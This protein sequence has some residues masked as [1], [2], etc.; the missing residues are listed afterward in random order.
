MR[1]R[2]HS[3]RRTRFLRAAAAVVAVAAGGLVAGAA[4]RAPAPSP[5]PADTGAVIYV[6]GYGVP[7]IFGPTDRSVLFASAWAQADA[8][9]KLVD[10][11]FT[12]ALG[13]AAEFLGEGSLGDDYLDRALEIP[14]LAREE[15]ERESPRMRGLLDAY[16]DG[17]NAWLAA[18]P[19]R[20]RWLDRVEPWYA[21]ALLRF[22]YDE[23]EFLGYAGFRKPMGERLLERGW[24]VGKGAAAVGRGRASGGSGGLAFPGRAS[25][26]ASP[27][28]ASSLLASRTIV[29]YAGSDPGP[30]GGRILGSNE[31]ALAPSR[32]AD[33][34]AYLLVNPHQSFF[35]V[36]RYFEIHIHSDQGLAFSGLTRFGFALPYMGHNARLGWAFTDNYADIGDL[37]VERF[38]EP[39]HPL[40]YRYGDGH[41]QATT[42]TETVKVKGRDGAVAERTLRFWKTHHGP[43]VG[44]DSAGRPLAARLAKLREGGWDD[45]LDAMIRARS[46]AEFRKAVSRLDIPYMNLMYADADGHIWYLYNSAVPRRDTAFDWRRP[47]DG[48]D[49]R[50]E[51]HG[52]HAL[53]EL[54][55]VLDPKSGFLLNTNSAPMV[56]T[57]PRP[58]ARSDFPPT[59]I[60][61][62]PDN[63]RSQSSR[64][65][66]AAMHGETF[67]RFA[68]AVWDT[69]LAAADSLVP[70]W[71][72]AWKALRSE[73][74]AG[75]R[76]RSGSGSGSRKPLPSQLAPGGP[77]RADLAVAMPR[78][79][80]WDREATIES[81]ETT[82]FELAV[83]K[84]FL[85]GVHGTVGPSSPWTGLVDLAETLEALRARW[86]TL[87]VPWGQVNR[88]QRPP[89]DD[90]AFLS[91]SLP[92]VAVGGAAGAVFAF[93]PSFDPAHER[94]TVGRQYG[95][96]GNSTLQVVDFGAE[97]VARSVSVFGQSADP[98]SPHF[99]DQAPLYALRMFKPAWW[100]L[101]EVQAHAARTYRPGE[102][103]ERA[104]GSRAFSGAAISADAETAAIG[105]AGAPKAA[106]PDTTP[107]DAAVRAHVDSLA[108]AA[109]ADGPGA[110]LTIGVVRGADTL[111]LG[112]WGKANVELGA[113][114]GP[115]TVYRIGSLTKQFTAALLMREV[116][117]GRVSLDDPLSKYVPDYDTHGK[118]V[119]LRELLHHTSGVP[120]YT[121]SPRF[122]KEERLDLPDSV[123]LD[124]GTRDSLD[125][126]P[127][128]AG[129]TATRATTCSASCWRR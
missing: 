75:A 101:A 127:R 117:A 68:R 115:G 22:K 44:L 67:D 118:T 107:T 70:A 81:V 30:L 10:E 129:R 97:P 32:T 1:A 57:V 37:Y 31:W 16:A 105:A 55:Q 78:L 50:T 40:A 98:A 85:A 113:A 11:N 15:Y 27:A 51:W 8:D 96:A 104:S 56:A 66:L 77:G 122:E 83:D 100:T 111:V 64:R 121:A 123:V 28:G 126:P 7:H 110:G 92:S 14:R 72:R 13:R 73:G 47:V 124:M 87:E 20:K 99:F 9:W 84:S 93:Y 53:S 80:A 65:A 41:R 46:L 45:Q 116:E 82:W 24:P 23:L 29:R 18:H 26:A 102:G 6:D 2:I 42:W 58:F 62:E 35:G 60:G 19:D 54:P 94:W 69:N 91:D 48:S 106:I 88:L 103:G 112:G 128:R 39:G 5:P 79:A 63:V 86:G 38:D 25:A 3:D 108:R 36:Q 4:A 61:P 59:M 49:P 119:T 89:Q 114:A 74:S 33:G 17:F 21:L 120:N 71:E 109:L 90:P 76:A 12:R 95:T 52:Y 125:F 43:V 34:H